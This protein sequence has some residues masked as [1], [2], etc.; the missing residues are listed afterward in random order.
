M[1][2]QKPGK[3]RQ[4]SVL[5]WVKPQ[6]STIGKVGD[7][8]VIVEEC[9]ADVPEQSSESSKNYAAVESVGAVGSHVQLHLVGDEPNQLRR[10]Q[11]VN[12]LM[13]LHAHRD[14][15]DG[16]DIAWT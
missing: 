1:A 4:K 9:A 11:A 10:G 7:E 14:L 13:L 8:N 3:S 2:S 6:D 12:Q 16:M 5:Y 15:A